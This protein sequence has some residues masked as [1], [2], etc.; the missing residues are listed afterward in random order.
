MGM[1]GDL[2]KYT[3]YQVA[4]SIPLAAQNEGGMAGIG[5]GLAAGMSTG[6]MM[7]QAMA[8]AMAAPLVTPAT[9]A[10]VAAA[11]VAAPVA[12]DNNPQQQLAQLKALLD[13]GLIS[14][15]DYDAAKAEVIKKLVG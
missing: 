7:A 6:Q 10:P 2:N 8:G 15:A 14:A 1:M 4:N 11:P 3:Q 13:Q 9:A 12:A 5:A